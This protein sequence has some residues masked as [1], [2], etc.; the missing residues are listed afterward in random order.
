LALPASIAAELGEAPE[1]LASRTLSLLFLVT[2]S[3]CRDRGGG[4]MAFSK[5][6]KG[7]I[8]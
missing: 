6:E 3:V 5:L 8:T 2:P 4:E 7:F 1:D